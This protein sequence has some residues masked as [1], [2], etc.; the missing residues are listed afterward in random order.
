MG[1]IKK[2]R[3]MGPLGNSQK[4]TGLGD[5]ERQ[6]TVVYAPEVTPKEQ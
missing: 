4:R 1:I 5:T 3:G 6:G 2:H